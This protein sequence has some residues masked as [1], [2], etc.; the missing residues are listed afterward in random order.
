MKCI[1]VDLCGN[2]SIVVDDGVDGDGVDCVEFVLRSFT[3]SVCLP[4]IKLQ[5]F[6]LVLA[7]YKRDVEWYFS[8]GNLTKEGE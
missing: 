2:I 3:D 8:V 4:I 1:F 5:N 6:R 7:Q